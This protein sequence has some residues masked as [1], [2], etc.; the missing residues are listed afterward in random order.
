MK[1]LCNKL[2]CLHRRLTTLWLTWHAIL[3]RRANLRLVLPRNILLPKISI[4]LFENHGR[5][6]STISIWWNE[7]LNGRQRYY[8]LNRSD[9]DKGW[10]IES[11][12]NYKTVLLK[13]SPIVSFPRYEDKRPRYWWKSSSLKKISFLFKPHMRPLLKSWL[14]SGHVK[15]SQ[16]SLIHWFRTLKWMRWGGCKVYLSICRWYRWRMVT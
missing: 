12:T 16:N 3:L 15:L 2:R 8:D 14:V 7:L 6:S 5:S 9:P 1:S 10:L 11:E 13:V 4:T